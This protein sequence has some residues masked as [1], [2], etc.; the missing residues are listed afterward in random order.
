MT[1]Q[2]SEC[3]STHFSGFA[4]LSDY[5][6][7]FIVKDLDRYK[8]CM[9]DDDDDVPRNE[10]AV[11]QFGRCLV[12]RLRNLDFVMPRLPRNP[13]IRH[14]GMNPDEWHDI[15]PANKIHPRLPK[16]LQVW[17]SLHS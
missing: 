11:V 4:R 13:P 10:V 8:M 5:I 14:C 6:P 1:D 9:S 16:L 7:C 15:F 3:P 17:I 2:T 12:F